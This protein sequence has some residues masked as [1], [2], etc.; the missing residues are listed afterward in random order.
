MK[1][2]YIQNETESKTQETRNIE[3]NK[4]LR[5]ALFIGIIILV[6]IIVFIFLVACLN[7]SRSV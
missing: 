2:K 6:V 4:G 5:T 7:M 3:S 1:K